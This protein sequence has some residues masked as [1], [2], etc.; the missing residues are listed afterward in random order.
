SDARRPQSCCRRPTCVISEEEMRPC[1][2]SRAG[3]QYAIPCRLR[4]GVSCEARFQ[5]TD[6]RIQE[7]DQSSARLRA[8]RNSRYALTLAKP[9]SPAVCRRE[10][11]RLVPYDSTEER[12]SQERVETPSSSTLLICVQSSYVC[13]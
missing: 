6:Q 9:L 12:F 10:A 8:S 3:V 2:T 11:V 5:R 7:P 13:R 4:V 1:G